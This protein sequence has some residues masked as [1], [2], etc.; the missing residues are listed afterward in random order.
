MIRSEHV[1]FVC[2][3]F[4]KFFRVVPNEL[5]L[6]LFV[7]LLSKAGA[8]SHALTQFQSAEVNFLLS[9]N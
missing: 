5:N 6:V 2:L 8:E 3:F 1:H 9:T 4:F 7:P